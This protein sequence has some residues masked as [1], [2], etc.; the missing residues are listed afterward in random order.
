M[1]RN[2]DIVI[3]IGLLLFCAFAAWRTSKVKVPVEGTI[4]GTSFVPW[5]MIG[6]IVLLSVALILRA[7]LRSASVQSIS[8][9]NRATLARMG[10]FTLLMIAYAFAFMNIGY[11][12]S[13][14][15][16][17][18]LGLLLFRESRI[19]VLVLFPLVMTG[20]I[21]LGFTKSLGVW[22]P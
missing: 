17:F 20:A 18:V 8:L 5:I 19:P 9:P 12:A 11:I 6:G 7:G 10:L 16:V 22:L 14:L 2:P 4:A 21:Y 13:T 1:K 3:G 15:I